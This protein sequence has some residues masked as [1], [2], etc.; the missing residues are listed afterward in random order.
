MIPDQFDDDI[1]YDIFYTLYGV[2]KE[3]AIEQKL[4]FGHRTLLQIAFYVPGNE[5]EMWILSLGVPMG[6]MNVTEE[7][8]LG[9]LDRLALYISVRDGVPLVPATWEQMCEWSA[10]QQEARQKAE[11]AQRAFEMMPVRGMA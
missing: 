4:I 5:E 11:H 1:N 6:R 7:A 2:S 10:R 3:E 9:L 8:Y